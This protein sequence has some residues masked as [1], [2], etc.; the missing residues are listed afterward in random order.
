MDLKTRITKLCEVRDVP[1]RKLAVDIGVTEQTM[2]RWF[3]TG[4]MEIKHL[5]KIADYFNQDMVYFFSDSAIE[6]NKISAV[7]EPIV[8]YAEDYREKYIEVLEANMKLSEKLL[9]TSEELR[10]YHENCECP[11][12]NKPSKKTA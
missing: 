9:Q 6:K 12:Q 3:R 10:W 8:K 7:S 2:H 4:T 5:K 1:I 11:K